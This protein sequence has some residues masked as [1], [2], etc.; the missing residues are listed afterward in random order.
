[1]FK[2]TIIAEFFTTINLP[3]FLRT[4]GLLT[5]KLPFLRYGKSTKNLEEKLLLYLG[6]TKSKIITLYNGRSAL[7][8][9]LKIIWVQKK[10]EVIVSAYT[11]ISV[12]NAVIQSGAKIVYS[13][14]EKKNLSLD[15]KSLEK[16][17]TKNTKAIIVQ[18][19]FWKP[20]N[21]KKIIT[22]A[23]KK[24]IIVIEDC[25][26]SLRSKLDGVK[27]W[28]YG[29]FAIFSTGRDK[30]ISSITWWFL[31]INNKKYFKQ[32]D[33]V[34]HT[35]KMPS[36]TL[37]IRNLIYNIVAYK[38]YKLY[39][40]LSIGKCIICIAKT[41]KLIT[42]IISQKEKNCEYKKFNLKLPN[43]LAYLASKELEKV[44]PY[45]DHRR[46]IATYYDETLNNKY[47]KPVFKNLSN[48]KNNYFRYPVII[49]SEEIKNK[50]YYYMRKNKILLWNYWSNSNIVPI[51]INIRKTKYQEN[52]CQI[53]EEISSK[54]LTL[55]NHSNISMKDTE[56]TISLLNKFEV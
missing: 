29:D 50:L 45:S 46:C 15:T 32:I 12:V 18:H 9:S 20:S 34:K 17:I 31:V 27:L 49:K 39:D 52:S 54:I 40:F 37:T 5:L 44:K 25:A 6:L 10:D 43:S 26:H 38:A 24:N 33:K 22:L 28:W 19:T 51:W 23:K 8:Q 3:I 4:I 35:L 21:I 30:V 2:K 47:I 11:C 16:N 53:A 36:R 1:M 55:P 56:K 48:E 14:I 42:Q 41:T 7:Y 13:D